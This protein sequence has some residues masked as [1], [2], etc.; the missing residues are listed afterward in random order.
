MSTDAQTTF[1]QDL[2]PQVFG[3]HFSKGE[4]HRPNLPFDSLERLVR[5]AFRTIRRE[6]DHN[7][8]AGVVFS[9]DARDNAERARS[10]A[11]N[12]LVETPGRAT[13][14]VLLRFA[15]TPGFPV[16]PSQ[17]RELARQRAAAAR[18]RGARCSPGQSRG[19]A[20]LRG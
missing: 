20:V 2:L 9:P 18:M 8:P 12:Q 1:V 4:T 17:L 15:A 10:A 6:D 5:L 7:R 3:D 14:D 11:F 13:F 16:S 19:R